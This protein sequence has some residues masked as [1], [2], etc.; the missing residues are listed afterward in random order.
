[1]ADYMGSVYLIGYGGI[2]LL[3]MFV[4]SKVKNLR[5]NK[6]INILQNW[7]NNEKYK[8]WNVYVKASYSSD[9]PRQ[10]LE[11]VRTKEEAISKI[12]ELK[13]KYEGVIFFCEPF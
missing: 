2:L 9:A 5:I 1:M 13:A 12:N 8:G 10:R 7:L 11:Q 6:M 4:F 3:S